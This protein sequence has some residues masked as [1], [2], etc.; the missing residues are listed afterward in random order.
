M[1]VTYGIKLNNEVH[2]TFELYDDEQLVS[3]YI[4]DNEFEIHFTLEEFYKF[5]VFMEKIK[6]IKI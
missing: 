6:P 5:I 1:E 2:F 4:N 3:C